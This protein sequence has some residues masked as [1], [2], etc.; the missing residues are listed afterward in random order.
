MIDTQNYC[1]CFSFFVDVSMGVDGEYGSHICMFPFHLS[2]S[3]ISIFSLSIFHS[4]ST[5]ALPP[6]P[7]SF[8]FSLYHSPSSCFSHSH[9]RSLS[10]FPLTRFIFALLSS[11]LLSLWVRLSPPL[12][13]LR[14]LLLPLSLSLSIISLKNAKWFR[15]ILWIRLYS[16]VYTNLL[17]YGRI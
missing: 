1:N 8:L 16:L 9:T 3:A 5:S 10:I 11:P 12:P 15:I 7:L 6:L 4:L 13:L 17:T 14:F 2:S